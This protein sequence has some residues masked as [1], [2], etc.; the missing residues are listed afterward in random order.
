MHQLGERDRWLTQDDDRL[1]S[2]CH[3]DT[4]RARGPGGH[5]R[6]KT[7]SAV[8]LRHRPSG[9]IAIGH[10]SRSQHQNKARALKRLR[11]AIALAVREPVDVSWK[12]PAV[13]EKYRR[14]GGGIEISR[15]S[16]DYPVLL[17]VVLD[18]IAACEGNLRG[19]TTLL[20]LKTAQLS[21][22]IVSERK[23]LDAVNRIRHEAGLRPLSLP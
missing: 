19:T 1:L 11:L 18:A 22:F 10:E 6:N 23:L 15:R 13:Y 3:V 21:K 20:R 17:A 14:P 2:E 7:S 4:Y 16:P 5:K 8:R 9:V 12:P